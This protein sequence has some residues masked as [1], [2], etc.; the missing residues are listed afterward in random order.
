VITQSGDEY[1]LVLDD[2]SNSEHC[3]GA[4]VHALGNGTLSESTLTATFTTA[5][6]GGSPTAVPF[7]V[8]YRSDSDT[9]IDQDNVVYSRG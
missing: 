2:S 8:R 1:D 7:T 6:P 5:C 3:S 9:L 4:A